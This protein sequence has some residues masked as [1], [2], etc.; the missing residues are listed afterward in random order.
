MIQLKVY[1]NEAQVQEDQYWLDLYETEPIKLT[2]A[3]EDITNADATSVFSKTFKVPATAHNNEF[4]KNAF[5]VDGID[6][7]VTKKKPAEI[8]VDGSEFRQGHIRLEKIYVNIEGDQIDYEILFLGETRDFSSKIADKAMCELVM[9]DLNH[10]IN[11]ENIELSWLA[12]PE[13]P[14]LTAGLANGNVI[15]PLIDF[16]NNYDDTGTAVEGR[17][18][19]EGNRAFTTAQ[20]GLKPDRFKPMIRAKRLIDQ[21][22]SDA[23]YTYESTFLDSNLFKQQYV[24]A[25][26]NNAKVELDVAA[27]NSADLF[28]ASDDSN[29]L[30]NILGGGYALRYNE[31]IYDPGINYGNNSI[32]TYYSCPSSGTYT[33]RLEVYAAAYFEN[34]DYTQSAGLFE[35]LIIKTDNT[36]IV[37][38][39]YSGGYTSSNSTGIVQIT[40]TADAGD[41]IYTGVGF[42][43]ANQEIIGARTFAVLAAPGIAQVASNMDC[44]YK[45]VDFIKDILTMYRLVMAPSTKKPNHFIIE[46]WVDYINKGQLY[47]WTDKLVRNKDITIEPL[48][49]T[50]SNKIEFSMQQDGD[51]VNNY[52]LNSYKHVYGWLQYVSNNELLK[53]TREVKLLSMSPTPIANVEHTNQPAGAAFVLPQIHVHDN[54]EAGAVIHKPIRAKTRILFYNGLNDI[55]SNDG[56]WHWFDDTTKQTKYP[57]ATPYETWPA[58]TSSLNL[59]WYDDIAYWD[60]VAVANPTKPTLFNNYWQA[61]VSS[62]YNKFSRRLTAYFILN[63]VDLQNFSF[64]DTIFIDGTYYMPEKIIDV[65][66]GERTEVK[67]QLIKAIDYKPAWVIEELTGFSTETI[68]PQC[69]GTASGQIIITTNGT[70]NFSWSLSTGQSGVHTALVG[71][72]PY[73]WTI[74][75]VQSGTIELTVIDSLQRIKT[76]SVIVPQAQ[77]TNINSTV[78]ITNANCPACDGSITVIPE[79]GGINLLVVGGQYTQYKTTTGLND[80]AGLDITTADFV[81]NFDILGGFTNS[82]NPD[83]ARVESV[84]QYNNKIYVLGIFDQY[85]GQSIANRIACLNPDG[86][87]DT[88][89]NTN[90]GTGLSANTDPT[91][92]QGKLYMSPTGK[93]YVTGVTTS[94]NGTALAGAANGKLF[95]LNLDGTLNSDFNVNRSPFYGFNDYITSIQFKTISDDEKLYISGAFTA[96]NSTGT[97]A[98]RIISLNSN[99][100]INTAFNYGS[101]FNTVVLDMAL[102]NDKLYCVLS[103]SGGSAYTYNGSPFTA[104]ICAINLDGSLDIAFKNAAG[105]GFNQDVETIQVDSTGLYLA[106]EFSSYNGTA[107]WHVA[108]L[109]LDA[110]LNT[111]F[112]NSTN[113]FTGQ[114]NNKI[115]LKLVASGLYVWGRFASYRGFSANNL[116]KIN[117]TDGSPVTA[118]NVGSGFENTPNTDYVYTVEEITAAGGGPYTITWN[119]GAVGPTLSDVCAG[120]YSYTIQDS[121]GCPTLPISVTVGCVEQP[122]YVYEYAKYINGCESLQVEP[123]LI[124]SSAIIPSGSVFRLSHK[125]GCFTIVAQTTGTASGY[126]IQYFATCEDCVGDVPTEYQYELQHYDT[127]CNYTTVPNARITSAL[128]LNVGDV[129]SILQDIPEH[130]TKCY[131]VGPQ[132]TYAACGGSF[133]CYNISQYWNTCEAC[134]SQPP[135]LY[136]YLAAPCSGF[137]EQIAV[138]VGNGLEPRALGESVWIQEFG[139][140]YELV[141]ETTGAN[142]DVLNIHNYVDCATCVS[143]NT[144][145]QLWSSREE[146][147]GTPTS[148]CSATNFFYP[149]YAQDAMFNIGD[150]MYRDATLAE[151]WVGLNLWYT[152]NVTQ[153]LNPFDTPASLRIDYN[154]VIQEIVYCI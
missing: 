119:T 96:Y 148:N 85:K 136:Y 113:P 62:L 5:L 32:G 3:I 13:S 17:I 45:Q 121:A 130:E 55:T 87:L 10:N 56:Y 21:I 89:F 44:T 59:N 63:N 20:W 54:A 152:V 47:D 81:S 146:D 118:F 123:D 122:E 95:R 41:R 19:L 23:G 153:N 112:N 92:P 74:D 127:S 7:D 145:T 125:E 64:D 58:T 114:L 27:V 50:Q 138:Q 134:N 143:Q 135:S 66:I 94:Y 102:Y 48:F 39:E 2:I 84:V 26:G 98:K 67:V 115:D 140:C 104:N 15:Y 139:E 40:F 91:F 82:T 137:G 86:T 70:P 108:K 111:T 120:T 12:Y 51:Y 25:F 65:Q 99:G 16:G 75:N 61:Y 72:A 73:T 131:R 1:K 147:N 53:G 31:S 109:G 30:G 142:F 37:L 149:I 78:Q 42:A 116:V 76:V 43:N 34:S 101:G 4:F 9:P 132:L 69:A 106:G 150:V 38:Q 8:L 83:L 22:F 90:A 110:T 154:G 151:T 79:G 68:A 18:A 97:N 57:L 88:T 144:S 103:G 35:P 129:C 117:T 141:G 126:P 33:V 60:T 36:N 107:C 29:D 71:Q 100:S 77:V 52:H 46:P 128:P 93:L 133:T 11:R 6:F 105:I 49:N 14:S 28:T 80:I 124:S 24:S